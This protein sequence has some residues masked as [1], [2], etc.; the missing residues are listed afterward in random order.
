MKYYYADTINLTT[1]V[2][3]KATEIRANYSFKTPD[4]IHLACAVIGKAN[5]F[6]TND[7][8]LNAFT[9]VKV[10]CLTSEE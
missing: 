9:E 3:D 2:I 8:R 6:V 4:S 10:L 1:E 7:K 5:F